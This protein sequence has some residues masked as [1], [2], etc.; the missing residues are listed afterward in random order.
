MKNDYTEL[1]TDYLISNNGLATATGLSDMMEGTVSHDQITRFLSKT[2]FDSKTLWKMVK[3]TV[4]EIEDDDGCI[5]FDDTIIDKQWTD[6]SDV[7]CWHYDHAKGRNIKGV[8]LLNMLYYAKEVA[9]P[10]GFEVIKKYAFCEIETKQKKR[11]ASITKNELMRNMLQRALRNQ[12]P[13][14]FVLMDTWFSAVENLEYIVK[15]KKEFVTA[16]KSNRYFAPS[17]E[18]KYQGKFHRVDHFELRDKQTLRGYLKGYDKEVLL[19]R[20]I[21]TNKDG[22]VGMLNLIC[23][24]TTLDGDFVATIYEKRWKVEEYHK[25]LKSNTALGKSPT[26]TIKTQVNHIVLSIMAFFKLESLKIKHHLNHFA[27]RAKLLIRANQVAFMELQRLK[28]A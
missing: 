5:I 21:F 14:R 10:I 13:F 15:R 4:R 27:L 1:Y 28:G 12:I 23:S 16:V 7:I 24:D 18:D 19:V 11:K 6:E 2:T 25:S 8:N 9:I 17:L 22:S 26:K 3:P 20:R